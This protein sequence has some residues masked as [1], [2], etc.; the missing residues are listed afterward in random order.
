MKK[1]YIKKY[2]QISGYGVWIVD[3]EYV[4]NN[5]DG[6]F[7][8]Y[9]RHSAFKFIPE[10]QFWIDQEAAGEEEDYYIISMLAMENLT[11]KGIKYNQAVRI[12]DKIEKR[13]RSK[14]KLLKS[15]PK[16]VHHK[17]YILNRVHR[18]LLKEYSKKVKIWVVNGELVRSLFFLDFTEGGHDRVYPFIPKNEVW[19]DDDIYPKERKFVLLHELHERN[20]MGKGWSYDESDK[21]KMIK[22]IDKLAKIHKSAHWAAA[23]IEHFF[24]KHP[25]GIKKQLMKEV[26]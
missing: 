21:R 24:R 16:R 20:L 10:N 1:P 13:E 5:M 25:K 19:I 4:R 3:G 7:T 18:K 2:K 8:N 11:K 26:R 14:S 6:E 12:A 23:R 9:G 15:I 17:D 22:D